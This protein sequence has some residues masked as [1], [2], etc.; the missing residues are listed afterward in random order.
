MRPPRPKLCPTWSVDSVLKMLKE[1][2][3][4]STLDLKCLT[5]KTAMLVALVSSKR[6]SSLTLLSIKEGF[7]E[8]GE[9]SVRFQPINLEKSE[10]PEH[11]AGPLV[12]SQFS[13]DP[14]ICPVQ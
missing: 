8:I 11:F 10:G 4:A 3:P 13:D 9:S 7:C 12:F 6:P 1:W 2:S 14:R 5:L